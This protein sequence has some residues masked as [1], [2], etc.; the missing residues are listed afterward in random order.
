MAVHPTNTNI[1]ILGGIDT[2][3][4]TNGG[5]SWSLTS[6]WTGSCKTYLHADQHSMQF[7]PGFNN[8]MILGNDGGVAYSSKHG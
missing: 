3:R 4:S 6:Y 5:S 8:E 2:Y 1:V 7:R